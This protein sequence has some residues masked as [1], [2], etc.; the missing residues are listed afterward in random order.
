MNDKIYGL[1]YGQCL[2]DAV[3][4]Q[5]EFKYSADGYNVTFPYTE[6]I[7]NFPVC[8][9]TDDS[10]HM[11]IVMESLTSM[12][13]LDQLDIASRLTS[14]VDHG[15]EELGDKFGTGLGGTTATIVRD[16]E[17]V[18]NPVVVANRVW[19]SSGKKLAPNG[20][21]MRTS[22]ISCIYDYNIM[23]QYS[24]DLCIITHVDTRCIAACMMYNSILH[25][26]MYS[27]MSFDELFVRGVKIAS[28]YLRDDS[29][30]YI[31]GMRHQPTPAYYYDNKFKSRLEE[32]IYYA[33]AGY[34]GELN[35]LQLDSIG[36]IGYV[37]KC[38]G[39]AMYGLYALKNKK[40]FEYTITTLANACGDA[41]TNC[42]VAGA[43][44]GSYI[45][46]KSLPTKWLKSLP[47]K[48]WL[49]EKIPS[50]IKFIE[51]S[52]GKN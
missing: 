52:G 17:F 18:T 44:I 39:A 5:T 42:A 12:K 51:F 4:L 3:G 15:F 36:T 35:L 24:H 46:Y 16:P 47:N 21:L 7:G 33:R 48:K 8:D 11:I 43:L 20:S 23:L 13:K 1:I 26:L 32:L 6:P 28:V 34:K 40:S 49:D 30:E 10:D 22:I 41:D 2:G 25:G 38:L 50:F 29:P 19:E 45:G 37:F 31:Q 14:W 9:W 27:D